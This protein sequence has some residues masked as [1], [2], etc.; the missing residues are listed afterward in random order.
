MLCAS[1]PDESTS[2]LAKR[3]GVANS[4]MRNLLSTAYVRLHVRTRAGAITRLEDMNLI[5]KQS[6][7]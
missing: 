2:T 1:F 6:D 7:S 5:P 3:M 4:T